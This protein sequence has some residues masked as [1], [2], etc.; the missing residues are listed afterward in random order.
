VTDEHDTPRLEDLLSTFD[1]RNDPL[2]DLKAMGDAIELADYA[3]RVSGEFVQFES[4]KVGKHTYSIRVNGREREVP[5][6]HVRCGNVEV[7]VFLGATPD[8]VQ[9][10]DDFKASI[11]NGV[12]RRK[13]I[14]YVAAHHAC[15]LEA[16]KRHGNEVLDP[17]FE[18]SVPCEVHA[19]DSVPPVLAA[20]YRTPL[21][22]NAQADDEYW[23]LHPELDAEAAD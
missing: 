1:A 3:L 20:G 12:A 16:W 18:L 8:D 9:P 11:R 5:H 19:S 10:D 14:E 17:R 13:I 6:V 21:D 22:I 4:L 2:D 23:K 7:R 15:L